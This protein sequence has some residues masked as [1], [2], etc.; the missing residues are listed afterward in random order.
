MYS[1]KLEYPQ[2]AVEIIKIPA[3]ILIILFTLI[4]LCKLRIIGSPPS[5]PRRKRNPRRLSC[6]RSQSIN[7]NLKRR[8]LHPNALPTQQQAGTKRLG[9]EPLHS[10]I[11]QNLYYAIV[12]LSVFKSQ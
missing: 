11:N 10:S 7:R 12:K 9:N 8:A 4:L 2:I 6:F 5:A 1:N 3:K